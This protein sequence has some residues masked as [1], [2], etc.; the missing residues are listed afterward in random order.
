MQVV[1]RRIGLVLSE[2]SVTALKEFIMNNTGGIKKGDLSEYVEI[3]INNLV[4]KKWMLN[5]IE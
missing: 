4:K 1:R 2:D 5:S 3:A